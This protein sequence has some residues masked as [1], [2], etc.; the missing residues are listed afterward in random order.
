MVAGDACPW[1]ER[2]GVLCPSLG[3]ECETKKFPGNFLEVS[4]KLLGKTIEID[5]STL[6]GK[7]DPESG[8]SDGD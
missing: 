3:I 2:Q 7:T 5:H 1:G 8:G 4:R 6:D